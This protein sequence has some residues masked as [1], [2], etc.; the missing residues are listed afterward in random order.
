MIITACCSADRDTGLFI[1]AGPNSVLCICVVKW[2][3]YNPPPPRPGTL[4]SARGTG[5]CS[6]C[7]G[8]ATWGPPTS[9]RPRS[10]RSSYTRWHISLELERKVHTKV[11]NH[12]Y[13]RAFSWLIPLSHLG[14]YYDTHYANQP[15]LITFASGT[16]FYVYLQLYACSA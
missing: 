10:G 11:R 1:G 8:S 2:A 5:G 9:S 7:S 13:R 16:Q 14:I 3:G 12:A 15:A 4:W 6:W